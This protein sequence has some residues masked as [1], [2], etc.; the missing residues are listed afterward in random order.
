MKKRDNIKLFGLSSFFNDMG[1]DMIAPILP[2]YIAS[3]GGGGIALGLLSGMREGLASLLKIA[4][5]W[6]SD[7]I[8]KRK[9]FVFRINFTF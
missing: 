2:F 7:K 4:G 9:I 1:S 5:G 3:L 8:G 6:M